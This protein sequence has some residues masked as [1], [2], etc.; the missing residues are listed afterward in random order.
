MFLTPVSSHE[1]R[2]IL[3]SLIDSAPSHDGIR[4]GPLEL[5]MSYVEGPLSYMCNLSLN[6][7]SFPDILKIANVIQLYKKED[8]YVKNYRPVS[9]LCS[10]SKVPHVKKQGAV[11]ANG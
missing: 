9:L 2:K 3:N 1:F 8:Y 5:I 4:L 10:L 11:S 7:R 6:Q